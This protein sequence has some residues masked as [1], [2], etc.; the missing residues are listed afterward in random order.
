VRIFW[1]AG[2]RSGWRGEIWFAEGWGTDWVRGELGTPPT[3]SS[4]S[5]L[6]AVAVGAAE[7]PG[8]GRA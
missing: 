6:G 1:R 2:A 7:D 8:P 3:P 4:G 5:S